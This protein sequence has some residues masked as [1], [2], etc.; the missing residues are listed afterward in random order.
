MPV[1]E[2]AARFHHRLVQVHSFPN[3][4]GRWARLATDLLLHRLG[5]RPFDWGKGLGESTEARTRYIAALRRAD[6]EDYAP[7]FEFLRIS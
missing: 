4:N 3:G 5:E 6:Q 7:L 2:A 1:R